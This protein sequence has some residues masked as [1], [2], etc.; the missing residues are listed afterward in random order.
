M[1]KILVRLRRALSIS[2]ACAALGGPAA[3]WS[4]ASDRPERPNIV[5]ILAD[6]LGWRDLG[7]SGN[8]WHRTPNIDRLRREGMSFSQA[9]AA[10]PICAAS[11]AALLTGQTPARLRYEFVP[12][13]K[14]GFQP[15]NYPMQTPEYPTE[16]PLGTPTVG[17]VLKSNGYNTAFFGKW[18]LNRHHLIYKGWSPTHGPQAFG[19]DHTVE[20]F[21]AHPY[22]YRDKQNPPPPVDDG[23]F[24]EDSLTNAAVDFVKRNHKQPFLMWVS[25]YYVHDPFHSRAKWLLE[26]YRRVLPDDAG[27]DR[28]HYAAMVETLDHEVGKI[29]KALAEAGLAKNTLVIFM[30]DNGGH[31]SVSTNGP[32]RGSKWNL[33]Q[34]GTRV[35]FLIRWTGKVEA[36]S[37][38]DVPVTGADLFATLAE[39]GGVTDAVSVDGSSLAPLMMGTAGGDWMRRPLIWHFPYY[40]PEGKSFDGAKP[41]IGIQDFADRHQVRPHSALRIGNEKLLYFYEDDRTEYYDLATDPGESLNLVPEHPERAN[42]LKRHLLDYLVGVNARFPTKKVPVKQ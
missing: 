36:S 30:S 15:G 42:Q 16:L 7:Y 6:D 28:I 20:D 17:S 34:G 13:F 26:H 32:L 10:A 4:L 12:K 37:T 41:T 8:P 38:C 5:F 9:H 33:Y 11:R 23:L 39:L 14:A 25:F 2:M 31:P 22:S 3:T 18:H 24:P 27:D 1:N 35:P 29:T 21:G 19:F 40:H